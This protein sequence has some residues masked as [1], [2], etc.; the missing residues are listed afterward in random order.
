MEQVGI[1][2]YISP[3]K[4]FTQYYLESQP[5]FSGNFDDPTQTELK[6]T[7]DMVDGSGTTAKMLFQAIAEAAYKEAPELEKSMP[8]KHSKILNSGVQRK[9]HSPKHEEMNLKTGNFSTFRI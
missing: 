1:L 7:V 5:G 9:V 2:S 6:Y 8:K 3:T 4:E